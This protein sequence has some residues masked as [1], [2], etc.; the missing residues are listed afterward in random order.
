MRSGRLISTV[1]VAGLV[2]AGLAYVF[3]S[4]GRTVSGFDVASLPGHG[5]AD[6]PV[7]VVVVEDF[8]CASCQTFHTDVVAELLRGHVAAGRVQL[9]FAVLPAVRKDSL[10][11][12][13]LALLYSRYHALPFATVSARLF[14]ADS[15]RIDLARADLVLAEQFGPIDPGRRPALEVVART[16]LKE[17]GRYLVGR[18]VDRVPSVLVGEVLLFAPGRDIVF[19]EIERAL[20]QATGDA[21]Q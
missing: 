5:S 11:L 21:E 18:D 9:R 10:D 15:P 17:G 2:V 19:R 16:H 3:L 8:R 12:A 4:G 7:T 13:T 6:A 20:A 14:E 1:M